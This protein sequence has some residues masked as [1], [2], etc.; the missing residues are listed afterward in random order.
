MES[1]LIT[2]GSHQFTFQSPL[3]LK[4]KYVLQAKISD[5]CRFEVVAEFGVDKC[6][7]GFEYRPSVGV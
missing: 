5:Y 7:R 1:T 2:S 4:C 3:S 6:M